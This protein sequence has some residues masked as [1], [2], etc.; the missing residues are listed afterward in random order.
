[1]DSTGHTTCEQAFAPGSA[2]TTRAWGGLMGRYTRTHTSPHSA[3]PCAWVSC[4][5]PTLLS[6]LLCRTCL[7]RH[8]AYRLPAPHALYTLPTYRVAPSS[9]IWRL[10][11]IVPLHTPALLTSQASW[12]ACI[13]EHTVHP[14]T[15][16]CCTLLHTHAFPLPFS[17]RPARDFL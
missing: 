5:H 3:F 11:S 14:G 15:T 17:L 2:T 6:R 7:C 9:D 1:M 12:H 16:A 4:N 8:H 13:W 10:P